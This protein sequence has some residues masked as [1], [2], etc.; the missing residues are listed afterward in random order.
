[1]IVYNHN[2]AWYSNT[3]FDLLNIHL[4]LAWAGRLQH[5]VVPDTNGNET[6]HP[7]PQIIQPWHAW[8]ALNKL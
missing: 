5:H 3:Y 7:W 4:T 6:S 1:M 8:L 2:G